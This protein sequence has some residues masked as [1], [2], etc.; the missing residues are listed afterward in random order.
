MCNLYITKVSCGYTAAC[1]YPYPVEVKYV[2]QEAEGPGTKLRLIPAVTGEPLTSDMICSNAW[3]HAAASCIQMCVMA[4]ICATIA[5]TVT[6]LSQK[7]VNMYVSTGT[8]T[9]ATERSEDLHRLQLKKPAQPHMAAVLDS[10]VATVARVTLG[11]STL[12]ANL[13]DNMAGLSLKTKTQVVY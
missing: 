4:V 13:V 7:I 5:Y 9:Q 1:A 12:T 3:L 2:L 8:V 10:E 11:S 6:G